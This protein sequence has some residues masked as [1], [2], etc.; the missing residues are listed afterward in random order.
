LPGCDLCVSI[1]VPIQ[2]HKFYTFFEALTHSHSF[3]FLDNQR[4][5]PQRFSISLTFAVFTRHVS[6]SLACLRRFDRDLAR[7]SA[8][9]PSQFSVLV[10][11]FTTH[12]SG[13]YRTWNSIP[14]V[15]INRVCRSFE[16]QLQIYRASEGAS[17]GKYHWFCCDI[18]TVSA[19][20]LEHVNP[21]TPW[22]A[23][24]EST[25]YRLARV[26]GHKWKTIPG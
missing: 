24:E 5:L 20:K 22:T 12:R 2:F 10:L 16:A 23:E 17:I 7:S 1:L 19:W 25:V 9:R 14:Q 15:T 4:Q 26:V 3:H 13:M 18:S 11:D 21:Y 8:F 6:P